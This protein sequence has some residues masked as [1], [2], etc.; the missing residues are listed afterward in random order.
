MKLM[1]EEGFIKPDFSNDEKLAPLGAV[2]LSEFHH[3]W[4][5][6]TQKGKEVWA[7]GPKAE[8]A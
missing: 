6:P 5:G 1:L 3:Y 7:A 8:L 4:F 2:S